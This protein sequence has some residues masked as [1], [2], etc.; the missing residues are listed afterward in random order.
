MMTG[1]WILSR[2]EVVVLGLWGRVAMI[3]MM[4]ILDGIPLFI[5]QVFTLAFAFIVLGY[6]GQERKKQ[7]KP[8]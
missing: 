8:F 6:L 3:L 5:L 2:G 7:H 4:D 1:T